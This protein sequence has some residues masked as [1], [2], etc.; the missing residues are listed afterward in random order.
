MSC[1]VQGSAG[2][3]NEPLVVLKTLTAAPF[4]D[5]GSNAIGRTNELRSNRA[6]RK[7]IPAQDDIPNLIGKTLGHPIDF[8]LMELKRCHNNPFTM[9]Q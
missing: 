3:L 2:N 4:R 6:P 5:V 8:K 7:G 9:D 1:F